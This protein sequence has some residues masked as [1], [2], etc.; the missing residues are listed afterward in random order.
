MD[1]TD[2]FNSTIVNL[3]KTN[4]KLFLPIYL[5]N[6]FKEYYSEI[7]KLCVDQTKYHGTD[8]ETL[9]IIVDEIKGHK[10][11]IEHLGNS[12]IN[13]V[14]EYFKGYPN[15]A[16]NKINTGL[17]KVKPYINKLVNISDPNFQT[18]YYRM[19]KGD[20]K[21]YS[22]Y[23]MF[24]IPFEKRYKIETK[25]Y[26]ISG[27][28]CL[29]LG[30]SSY[31]CWEEL[32]KPNLNTIQISQLE[33]KN[34]VKIINFGFPPK[35]IYN[36]LSQKTTNLYDALEKYII[37][38]SILWPLIAS[39]SIKVK[40]K[41][42]NFKEEYII[43]QLLMQWV[44]KEKDIDGIRYFSIDIEK[45]PRFSLLY[46]NYAFPVKVNLLSQFGLCSHLKSL[47]KITDTLSYKISKANNKINTCKIS[48]SQLQKL[49]NLLNFNKIKL[50]K[51]KEIEY[52][53]T[54]FGKIE[55]L[56]ETM[57]TFDL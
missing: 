38:F 52:K 29:Y 57:P 22:K 15:E 19:R 31:V 24:H 8:G 18:A 17:I 47:F 49:P 44:H 7:D 42:H 28:P 11:D 37:S 20:N 23:E 46:Q 26:S 56:L 10:K 45:L 1:I 14:N 13:S 34:H 4:N 30:S 36:A 41:N 43:P 6:I 27:F 21:T 54:D 2:F 3:P 50:I 16:Y 25:R 53:N 9:D 40:E 32:D 33:P 35:Y 39:C 55:C 51:G 5:E 12:I 48:E